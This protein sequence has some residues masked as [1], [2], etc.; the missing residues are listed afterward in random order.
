MP[1]FLLL[2]AAAFGILKHSASCMA[3]KIIT[4]RWARCAEEQEPEG[5]PFIK[6]GLCIWW[7][8]EKVGSDG[9]EHFHVQPGTFFV[10]WIRTLAGTTNEPL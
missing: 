6:S 8:G 5:S 10:W 3:D 9:L 4:A 1:S 2:T 7:W